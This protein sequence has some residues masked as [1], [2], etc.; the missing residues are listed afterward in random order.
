M[1]NLDNLEK[2]YPN[3]FLDTGKFIKFL[4]KII[5]VA[6]F[7]EYKIKTGK[8]I[9]EMTLHKL[10]FFLKKNFYLE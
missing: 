1:K 2:T 4:E 5:D 6:K 10:T 9:D 8:E 3:Y 7:R